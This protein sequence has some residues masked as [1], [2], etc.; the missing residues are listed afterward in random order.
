MGHRWGEYDSAGRRTPA[1]LIALATEAPGW[2]RRPDMPTQTPPHSS[3][4]LLRYALERSFPTLLPSK[5]WPH[6]YPC[7]LG[8]DSTDSGWV[9]SKPVTPRLHLRPRRGGSGISV[10]GSGS[11]PCITPNRDHQHRFKLIDLTVLCK[12]PPHSAGAVRTDVDEDFDGVAGFGEKANHLAEVFEPI[13]R[14]S[15]QLAQPA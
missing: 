12:A 4:V 5:R 8:L 7:P 15:E 2:T 11:A 10:W 9:E 3:S 14:V 1:A 13:D 6:S